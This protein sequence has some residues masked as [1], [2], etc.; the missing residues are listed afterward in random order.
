MPIT[1]ARLARKANARNAYKAKYQ[2]IVTV[3]ATLFPKL[4]SEYNDVLKQGYQLFG[5]DFRWAVQRHLQRH[6]MRR[7]VAM[8][9]QDSL[10]KMK[11]KKLETR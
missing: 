1:A 9:I 5:K 8:A 10:K 7:A 6:D 4:D 2:S 11:E 3:V